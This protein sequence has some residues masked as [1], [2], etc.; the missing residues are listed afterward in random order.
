VPLNVIGSLR[1]PAE[2]SDAETVGDEIEG[3]VSGLLG[4]VGVDSDPLSGREHILL[5]NLIDH[6]WAAG[7]DLDLATLVT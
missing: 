2:G 1:R 6:A 5:A 7:T 4:M 3:F